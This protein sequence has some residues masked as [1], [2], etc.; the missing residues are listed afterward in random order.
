MSRHQQAFRAAWSE[1]KV[2][3]ARIRNRDPAPLRRIREENESLANQIRELELQLFS[4]LEKD[5]ILVGGDADR[6][7]L[8]ALRTKSLEYLRNLKVDPELWQ[9]LASS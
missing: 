6:E 7:R 9:N 8:E 1:L 5:G 3:E 4:R 2:A